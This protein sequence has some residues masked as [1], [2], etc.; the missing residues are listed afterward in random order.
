MSAS[1]DLRRS[2][3]PATRESPAVEL[4]DLLEGGG[5]GVH[6]LSPD[7]T[8][9]WANRTDYERLGYGADDYVG[10]QLEEFLVGPHDELL[11]KLRAAEPLHEAVLTLRARDGS[12]RYVSLSGSP[13]YDDQGRL[14]HTRC[15][16]VDVTERRRLELELATSR[17]VLGLLSR[18]SRRFAELDRPDARAPYDAIARDLAE[19]FGDCCIVRALTREGD[20]LEL[21]GFHHRDPAARELVARSVSTREGL[22]KRALEPAGALHVARLDGSSLKEL[23][24]SEPTDGRLPLASALVL[25]LASNGRVRGVLA[26]G[27]SSATPFSQADELLLNE[28]ADRLALALML[29]E[30]RSE[31]DT[32]RTRLRELAE[33]SRSASGQLQMIADAIPALIAY[34]DRD[35]RYVFVNSAYERWFAQPRESIVGRTMGELLGPSLAAAMP[36]AELAMRGESVAFESTFE[37]PGVG[38]REVRVTYVPH[39]DESAEVDG[40][41]ILVNDVSHEREE[42]RA[43]EALLRAEQDARQRLTVIAQASARLAQSLDYERT[44]EALTDLTL[45]LLGDACICELHEGDSL[46]RI[47]RTRG[48]ADV[49][50]PLALELASDAVGPELTEGDRSQVRHDIDAALLERL[51]GSP[52]AVEA[53]RALEPRSLLSVPL[54]YQGERLGTMLLIHGRSGR[55]HDE[56]DL[57][58]AEEIVRRATSALVNA[59]LFKEA[60]DAIGVRDDFLSMAGHELRTPLTALQLQILSI[61]KVMSQPD[62]V[63]KVTNR[64]EKAGRNVL[65]LSNLVNELLDISRISSGRLKLERS[66]VDLG[67]AVREVLL[68]H[69]AELDQ[70]GC[71]IQLTLEGPATGSWDRM[72]VEQI[73]TNLLTNAMKYGKG[74]PIEVCVES[75]EE[76]ARLRIRDHG[77]GIPK[78]DQARIFQRFERAVS[79]RHFGGLGF[80]LWIARQLVDAHGGTIRVASESGQGA[81]FE[82]TL[83]RKLLGEASA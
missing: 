50:E 73:A 69:Q 24:A 52:Q 72:R 56:A 64:A 32:E 65:R 82:V 23:G 58:L 57:T 27:R 49:A 76:H 53:L 79:S 16:T 4:E 2:A 30:Q 77:I 71:A 34:V 22:A 40:L 15:L 35:L 61:T 83:P 10:H 78:E 14:V 80:G 28:V 3:V 66:P 51:A 75:D 7:L 62:G 9:L 46:R 45:P 1:T 39:H 59:R 41:V 6:W 5:L 25:P 47:V 21:R 42:S 37:Y 26:I 68:R 43:R 60:R 55:R 12:S 8:L 20:K 13:R 17:R 18:I 38:A 29:G 31:L 67:D 48:E 33:R 11:R 74:A 81:M 44:L 54:S 36:H 19:T 63:E 70:N